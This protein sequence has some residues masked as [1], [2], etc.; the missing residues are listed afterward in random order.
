MVMKSLLGSASKCR[1]TGWSTPTPAVR[2]AVR[3]RSKAKGPPKPSK[4]KAPE[5]YEPVDLQQLRS[6]LHNEANELP[7]ASKNRYI[8]PDRKQH[9]EKFEHLVAQRFREVLGRLDDFEQVRGDY[10]PFGITSQSQL[11]REISL[12]KKA[13]DKSFVLA[14]TKSA[15]GRLDNPLFWNLRNAYSKADMKG[16]NAEIKHA[17]QTFMMRNRFPDAMNKL[18]AELADMRFPYEWYPA[19]R[20]MQRTIHLHV[21]PTNSGKTY[22]ALKA[23]E[24]AKTGIYAGPLRLLAHE[25]YTRFTAKNIPCALVTGEEVRVPT[26]ADRYFHSCT[27]EMSPL[28]LKVD[29]AVIDEIQMIADDDRGWAWTQAVLG[30]QAKELHLCGEDR[31][32]GLIQ[33]LCARI[34]DKCVVHRYE[35]LNPLSVMKDSL[36]GNFQKL[37]KGDA[38]VSFSRFNLHQLKAGIEKV[39]GRRCAI[40]YGSLPPETRATQAALFNDPNNDYDFLVASDAIGMGLN[41]EIKRVVFETST[42][43]DGIKHRNLTVPEIKQIGG[44][45]GRYKTATAEVATVTGGDQA[46]ANRAP[47]P[48]YVTTLDGED[49]FVIDEGFRS[50]APQIETAGLFPPAVIL[51]KF[52]TF[53]PPQTPTSFI[54]S[55]LREL[56]RLSPRFHLCDFSTAVDIA[57]AIQQCDLSVAD[58]CVFLNAPVDF[59]T[60]AAVRA[61]QAF[62]RCVATMS[63]GHLLSFPDID[64][65]VLEEELDEEKRNYLQRLESLH[66]QIALYLWLSY[67][68]E[69]VFKSQALAFKVKDMVEEKISDY[70]EK[71][72]FVERDHAKLRAAKRAMAQAAKR[73]AAKILGPGE[74]QAAAAAA[75]GGGGGPVEHAEG[76]GRWEEVGHEEPLFE[77]DVEEMKA[78]KI[79]KA[80]LEEDVEG[81]V[82]SIAPDEP[83]EEDKKEQAQGSS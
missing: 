56:S 67:R 22:N 65:E 12:F 74:E 42:K 10:Q 40:V 50:E 21:G 63:D 41:L 45:A 27:V 5:R 70:L 44:R 47:T 54:L 6:R 13:L 43:Y 75:S 60:E 64:L 17:F 57:E 66:K 20:Q 23:L 11:E 36:G 18:H 49:L 72:N 61:L 73:S 16:L 58:R 80:T 48:G 31:A 30:I 33:E 9:Y 71:L 52:H 39:T 81:E 14:T 1:R 37:E 28:N 4:W 53:F 69:G 25:I 26:D 55:R 68:Y 59:R 32:V 79:V 24:N 29:V 78:A 38:V 82:Q 35:R 76:V 77:D 8:N 83:A 3:W 19:T 7:L 51:E 62:A 46:V 34:G 2:V 15:V